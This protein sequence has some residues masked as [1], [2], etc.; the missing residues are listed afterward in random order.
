MNLKAPVSESHNRGSK[1][2]GRL[3]SFRFLLFILFVA[4]LVPVAFA[5]WSELYS[6]F[7][8][9]SA[10]EIRVVEFPRGIGLTPVSVVLELSDRGAGLDEVVV[11]T[12]QRGNSKEILRQSLGGRAQA[13]V[14][15]DFPGEKSGLEEGSAEFEVRVFDRSFWN[16]QTEK[17]LPLKIDYRK[18]RVEVLTTQHNA[19]HGGSQLVFYKAS[20][21]TLILSGVKVGNETFLG[22][23]ARGIDSSFDDPSVFV[24]LYA[25]DIESDI[26]KV[27][28]RVFAED[29]V[30]NATSVSFYNKI[31]NRPRRSYTVNL[32]EEF[33]A[34]QVSELAE[35]NFQKMADAAKAAG[36]SIEYRAPKQSKER[37]IE[38]F[39]LVNTRLRELNEN[40]I[41]SLLKAP[42]FERYWTAPFSRQGGTI[43]SGFSDEITYAFDGKNIG[44]FTQNAYEILMSRDASEVY[45]ANDGIVA[46]AE[47]IG[48]YGNTIAIDHGLGLVSLYAHLDNMSV[49]RGDAVKVGQTI[50]YAGRS[51]LSRGLNMLF[52]LRVH[53]IPVDPVEWWDKSWFYAHINSKIE[54][55][56]QAL[57]IP[58]L[59]P[60]E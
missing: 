54:E 12:K 30:G 9:R 32:N 11:R 28:V 47:N 42:R 29:E 37:L 60:V 24:A 52:Q 14:T 31:Q 25:V 5:G 36:E 4:A 46:F 49:R 17:V 8:E 20:D 41:V 53:G 19:R 6:G 44:N 2:G 13:K 23:P 48:V 51:G 56:K 26:S 57:G 43:Q 39:Q 15:V 40:E 33:L 27:P 16:N 45:A 18:P 3:L 21:P 38:K 55:V 58:I 10:P 35:S 59:R 22:Y 1:S 7:L 50:G 34:R